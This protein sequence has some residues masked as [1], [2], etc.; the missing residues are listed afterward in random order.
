MQHRR[1]RADAQVCAGL[2]SAPRQEP[3]QHVAQHQRTG[4]YPT[5]TAEVFLGFEELERGYGLAFG[6]TKQNVRG[7]RCAQT[8]GRA[9]CSGDRRRAAEAGCSQDRREQRDDQSDEPM[10]HGETL[11]RQHAD[12]GEPPNPAFCHPIPFP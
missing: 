10:P 12:C 5:V 1:K 8:A 9:P 4:G 3:R 11:S 7:L 6:L 2:L